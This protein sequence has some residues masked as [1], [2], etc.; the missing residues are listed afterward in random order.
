M[1]AKVIKVKVLAE[2]ETS[3]TSFNDKDLDDV[4]IQQIQGWTEECLNEDDRIP[5]FVMSAAGEECG[6]KTVSVKVSRTRV[7]KKKP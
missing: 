6:E 1:T 7:P 4:A 5:L 3:F 2:I